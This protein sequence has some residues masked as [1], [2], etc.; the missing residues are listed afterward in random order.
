[1]YSFVSTRL[2]RT[3]VGSLSWPILPGYVYSPTSLREQLFSLRSSLQPTAIICM[4]KRMARPWVEQSYEARYHTV[5]S[6]TKLLKEEFPFEDP[7]KFNVKVLSRG[8][9]RIGE[10]KKTLTLK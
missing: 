6:I 5:A 2:F 4:L 8:L 9:G 1:M 7:S 3:N 10:Y